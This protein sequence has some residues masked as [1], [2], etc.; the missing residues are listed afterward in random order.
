MWNY[1]AIT[2]LGPMQT[3]TE[4]DLCGR[5]TS[6]GSLQRRKE[7]G[8]GVY[9]NI[10]LLDGFGLFSFFQTVIAWEVSRTSVIT[11]RRAP[12]VMHAIL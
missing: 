6:V 9:F 12:R 10:R 5:S 1:L 7:H 8:L 3:V 11:H 4:A 2:I